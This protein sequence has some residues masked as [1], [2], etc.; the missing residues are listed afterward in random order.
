MTMVPITQE[1]R[2]ARHRLDGVLQSLVR[3]RQGVSPRSHDSDDDTSAPAGGGG[4]GGG[5]HANE[6]KERRPPRKRRR[7]DDDNDVEGAGSYHHTYVMKL[8]DRSVDLAQFDESTSLYPIAR[9]WI[10][11][12]PHGKGKGRGD[13]GSEEVVDGVSMGKE[14]GDVFRLPPPSQTVSETEGS[15]RVPNRLSWPKEEFFIHSGSSD[16]QMDMEQ[17]AVVPPSQEQLLAS[18][19]GRWSAI[20]QQ[21]KRQSAVHESRYAESMSIIKNMFEE[22]QASLR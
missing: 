22:S 1:V 10:Q 15:G 18:H 2:S 12:Q 13:R 17:T 19:L 8:F 6:S 4:G 21:W 16:S 14:G 9:A 3:R 7:K 5:G 20:R 11:N